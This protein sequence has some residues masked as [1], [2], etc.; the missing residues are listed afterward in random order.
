MFGDG[1]LESHHEAPSFMRALL[2]TQD[3]TLASSWKRVLDGQSFD[4]VVVADGVAASR[5]SSQ[6]GLDL[7]VIAGDLGVV[8]APELLSLVRRGLFGS[9]P[10]PVILLQRD[11]SDAALAS[12]HAP[13]GC[14]L[15]EGVG[16]DAFSLAV[17]HA[18]RP[19][20]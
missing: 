18:L 5:L 12:E 10:P 13:F 4:T 1:P 8:S 11:A 3:P 16:E 14:V 9:S 20:Q 15:L 2:V 19:S 6:F 7:I 17:E